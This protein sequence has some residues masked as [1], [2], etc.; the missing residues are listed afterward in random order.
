MDIVPDRAPL[1]IEARI[2]PQD[3]DDIR[4]GQESIVR[5]LGLH[6]NSLPELKGTVTRLSADTF[7]DE[8]TGESY[9]T[10][11]VT[12]PVNQIEVIRNV[13]GRDFSLRAGMPVQLMV[14]LRKRTALEYAIEPLTEGLWRSF[15]EQ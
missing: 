2:S 10:T 14:P 4:V 5:F 9:F 3:A 11:E 6:E 15:G 7:V 8:K 13:R 12:V 1:L